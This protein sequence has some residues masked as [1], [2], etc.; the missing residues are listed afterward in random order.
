MYNRKLRKKVVIWITTLASI[1]TIIGFVLTQI[2]Q[3]KLIELFSISVSIPVWIVILLIVFI[4]VLLAAIVG[5]RG[6]DTDQSI[7]FRH[8]KVH[9]ITSKRKASATPVPSKY[10]KGQAGSIS[11][12]LYLQNFEEGIRKLVNNRYII[13]H[14]TNG[15]HMKQC[16]SKKAYVNAFALI[17]GPQKWTP[18][19]NPI[20]KIWLSN[21][22]G[23]QKIWTYNDSEELHPGW[24]HFLIR[25]D[26]TK[27]LFELLIDG[28]ETI[29]ADGYL[30]YWPHEY[31]SQ[32]FI[33]TWPTHDN[34]HFI[35]TWIWR[36]FISSNFLGNGWVKNEL[37]RSCPNPPSY[38]I[39]T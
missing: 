39:Q 10:L 23:D 34:C 13:G 21:G 17:N 29:Y 28:T 27:P 38:F 36:T 2:L 26:H 37:N 22:K 30:E 9:G 3:K 24:H 8:E 12:W 20:W 14:A 18:P 35:E 7:L 1:L 4:F 11:T 31:A 6:V 32:F 33:G 19:S 25:W 16:E 15:G 5:K